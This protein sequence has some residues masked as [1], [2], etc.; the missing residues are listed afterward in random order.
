MQ[1]RMHVAG[2]RGRA[3]PLTA[4]VGWRGE[5]AL[6]VPDASWQRFQLS[7]VC[8]EAANRELQLLHNF[9]CTRDSGSKPH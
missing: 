8:C 1:A 7:Q 2:C 5:L 3:M 9:S 4:E 6:K